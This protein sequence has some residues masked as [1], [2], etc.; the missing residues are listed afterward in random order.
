MLMVMNDL[1]MLISDKS[2]KESW[3]KRATKRML[4]TKMAAKKA[5]ETLGLNRGTMMDARDVAMI[6]ERIIRLRLRGL[7]T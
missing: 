6:H 1:R 3:M 7:I 4:R 2:W 5:M